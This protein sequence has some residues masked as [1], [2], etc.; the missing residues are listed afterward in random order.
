MQRKQELKYN[1]SIR[2]VNIKKFNQKRIEYYRKNLK[3]IINYRFRV[4]IYAS[5]SLYQHCFYQI[6]GSEELCKEYCISRKLTKRG[7][8]SSYDSF[9]NQIFFHCIKTV[10][11]SK[12]GP[13][14]YTFFKIH[15][16]HITI[17]KS[18]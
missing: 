3:Y 4:F 18:K 17:I 5:K 7:L 12:I 10:S 1:T 15:L 8:L 14:L 11:L 13:I 9:F 6:L 16:G 2:H